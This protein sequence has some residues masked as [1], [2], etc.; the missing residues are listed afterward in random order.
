M[1]LCCIPAR[2][3]GPL[4][5][6]D[7]A[8]TN[9]TSLL[10]NTP[11]PLGFND[12]ADP[13]IPQLGYMPSKQP[14]PICTFARVDGVALARSTNQNQPLNS[15]VLIYLNTNYRYQRTTLSLSEC[16]KTLPNDLRANFKKEIESVITKMHELGFALGV[17]NEH[18]AGYRTFQD[19]YEIKVCATKAGP[20]E[21][22][23]NYLCAVD[24]GFL[25]WVDENGKAYSDYWL[26]QMDNNPKYKGFSTILWEKRNSLSAEI[27]GL[28]F[29]VIHLQSV[30]EDVSGRSMLVKCLNKAATDA[31]DTNWKYRRQ[32]KNYQCTLGESS[33]NVWKSVGSAK[34]MWD[35]S[36]TNCTDEERKMINKHMQLA[37]SIAKCIELE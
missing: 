9:V 22:F 10:G 26:G 37:E 4:G 11:G 18:K 29:E 24:L 5:W 21:S 34:Q 13:S 30:P 36:A 16:L 6:N 19:Q 3:S 2:T 33:G 17:K 1:S 8:D 23:H 27:Y 31:K 20:G 32:G 28:S 7:Q 14:V 35:M 12:L 25:Q 15:K